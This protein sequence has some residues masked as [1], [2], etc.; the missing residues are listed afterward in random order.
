[1]KTRFFTK[2]KSQLVGLLLVSL[3]VM[4]LLGLHVHVDETHQGTDTHQHQA[5]THA[6][7]VHLSSHDSIDAEPGHPSDTPQIELGLDT[8]LHKIT[9]VLALLGLVLMLLAGFHGRVI[10]L[11]HPKYEVP[12][13]HSF[14][15]YNAMRRGPPAF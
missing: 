7:H 4:P 3:V 6:F 11:P 13:N 10:R 12:I 5:E 1:M 2:Y 8:Q 9:K 15:I 14:E